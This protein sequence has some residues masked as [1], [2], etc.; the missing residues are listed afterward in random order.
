M[1]PKRWF[2]RARHPL[3]GPDDSQPWVSFAPE[4]DDAGSRPCCGPAGDDTAPP[5]PPTPAHVQF[6]NIVQ[7]PLDALLKELHCRQQ[8]PCPGKEASLSHSSAAVKGPPSWCVCISRPRVTPLRHAE[9]SPQAVRPRKDLDSRHA[10]T[11]SC[12]WCLQ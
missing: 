12:P 2:A 7:V 6:G 11:Q 10:C 3:C 9:A 8:L 5:S 4:G 1:P